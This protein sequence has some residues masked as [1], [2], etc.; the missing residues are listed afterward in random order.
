MNDARTRSGRSQLREKILAA[1]AVDRTSFEIAEE[2]GDPGDL[3]YAT[4]EIVKSQLRQMER[5]GVVVRAKR[6]GVRG[7][8]IFRKC[9]A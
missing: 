3:P 1:L 9:A 6:K 4:Q 2:V 8:T 7:S 5:E